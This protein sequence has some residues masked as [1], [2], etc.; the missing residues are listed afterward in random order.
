MPEGEAASADYMCLS[1]FVDPRSQLCAQPPRATTAG[2]PC[3]TDGDCNTTIPY[4][5]G[6]CQCTYQSSDNMALCNAI[7]PDPLVLIYLQESMLYTC[8]YQHGCM[9]PS[10]LQGSSDSCLL[11]QCQSDY[12]TVLC[13]IN[14]Y[15]NI[16]LDPNNAESI[17]SYPCVNTTFF[18]SACSSSS[19]PSSGL[20]AGAEAA[21]ILVCAAFFAATILGIFFWVRRQRQLS[22][23]LDLQTTSNYAR[24]SAS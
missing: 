13:S 18:A 24:L 16:L 6:S 9:L 15:L 20:S 5:N 11:R 4:V 12:N 19:S 21:I 23:P 1:G 10:G 17:I 7:Y 8:A 3:N 14:T 22:T 2:Q